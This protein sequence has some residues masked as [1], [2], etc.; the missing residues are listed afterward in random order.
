MQSS[1]DIAP[2]SGARKLLLVVKYEW[3][4]HFRKKR[5]Y[6]TLFLSITVLLLLN[7]LLPYLMAP[8]AGFSFPGDTPL[9]FLGGGFFGPLGNVWLV[10]VILAIFFG[11][12]SMS[13][14]FENKTGALLF[15]NPI[16]RETIVTGKYS[17]S[18]LMMT[19]V[20]TVYY[21]ITWIFTMVFFGSSAGSLFVPFLWSYG[22]C[23][24]IAAGLL[25]TTFMLSAVFNKSMVTS[26]IVFFLFIIIMNIVGGIFNMAV[27]QGNF[28]FEP[29]FLISYDAD[30]IA[31]IMDY[32]AEHFTLG[33]MGWSGVPE[34]LTGLLTV[35]IG[36]IIVP[37][38]I[39]TVIY[40]RRD[41]S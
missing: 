34:I 22:I 39:A 19:I 23:I 21:F 35:L 4:K 29:W 3:L 1:E 40:K 14:E 33:P 27:S 13:T 8:L 10:L 37:M 9:D 24:L 20:L 31:L 16:K 15:P 28:Q 12:D 18:M 36:Y 7:I 25:A 32:P 11:S 41:I 2:I 26:I 30:L 17:A 5:L 38:G 6:I